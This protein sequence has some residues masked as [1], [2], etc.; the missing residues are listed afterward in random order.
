MKPLKESSRNYMYVTGLLC[1]GTENLPMKVRL[2]VI[3]APLLLC[4][5]SCVYAQTAEEMVSRCQELTQA[6]IT[7]EQVAIPQDFDSGMCWGAFKTLDTVVHLFPDSPSQAEL[8]GPI[9]GVCAPEDATIPQQIKIFVTYA[10][11][12]PEKLNQKYFFVA[13]AALK[14][15]FPCRK[16]A[17]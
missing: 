6:K 7:Q 4:F 9:F 8:T 14:E 16:S 17:P 13:V 5:V 10:D 11:K 1:R 2:S 15:A 12:H 3:F